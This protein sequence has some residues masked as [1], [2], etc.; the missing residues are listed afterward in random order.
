MNWDY[1]PNSCGLVTSKGWAS[2]TKE[3][4]K[5]VSCHKSA[6]SFVV[7]EWKKSKHSKN[8]VGC[9]ECHGTT[10]NNPAAYKHMGLIISTLVTPEQCARCHP[11]V[12]KE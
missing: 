3:S 2:F 6:T 7:K 5:C 10:K 1:I 8:G 11:G 9:Y 4:Q 12:V